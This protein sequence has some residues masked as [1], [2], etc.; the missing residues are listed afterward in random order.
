MIVD[1]CQ[2]GT[3]QDI[4]V[5]LP[6]VGEGRA[7]VILRVAIVFGNCSGL[8]G[9]QVYDTVAGRRKR[10]VYVHACRL[11]WYVAY[12]YC[13]SLVRAARVVLILSAESTDL[14]DSMATSQ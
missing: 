8:C 1:S 3:A 9:E 6:H 5:E 13:P 14:E 12:A 2:I 4:T 11:V 7:V 10:S